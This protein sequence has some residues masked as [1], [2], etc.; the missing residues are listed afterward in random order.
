VGTSSSQAGDQDDQDDQDAIDV[1]DQL[2]NA[3]WLGAA[4]PPGWE[5]SIF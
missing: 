3:F 1:F 5:A 2:R 4:P